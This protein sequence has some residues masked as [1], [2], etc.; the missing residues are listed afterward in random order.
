MLNHH[1]D[2]DLCEKDQSYEVQQIY[3]LLASSLKAAANKEHPSDQTS[4]APVMTQLE[5][6]SNNSGALLVQ[7]KIYAPIFFNCA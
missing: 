6:T 2:F 7:I 5:D 3:T 1:K 4:T